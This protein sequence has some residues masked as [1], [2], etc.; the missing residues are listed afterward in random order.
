MKIVFRICLLCVGWLSSPWVQAAD[1]PVVF[2]HGETAG[3]GDVFG[4]QGAFFG[5][6]AEVWYMPVSGDEKKLAPVSKL[7]VVSGSD[8]NIT[9]QLPVTGFNKGQLLAVW[10]KQGS[11]L[12]K[13]V[14]L[15][16]ARAVTI[17]FDELMPGQR[18]RI[19]GRNLQ[20][21]G[22][23]PSVRL[24]A[25]KG[26][27]SLAATVVKTDAYVME[28]IAPAG[29]RKDISYKIVVNNGAGKVWGES[30]AEE[31]IAGRAAAPDPLGLEVPWGADFVFANNMYN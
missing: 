11:A 7:V 17:E 13:P 14:F 18:F 29:V 22:Y 26:N 8:R 12:S 27:A 10:I 20:A 3:P 31:W 9:A 5:V 15:N 16:K 21:E 25:T 2:N 6:N 23:T 28:V 24:M 19:F 4:L 30:V 1:V